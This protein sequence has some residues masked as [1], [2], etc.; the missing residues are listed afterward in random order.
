MTTQTQ[1]QVHIE[2]LRQLGGNKFLAM[3]GAKNLVY[4]EKENNYLLMKLTR[5]LSG[6]QYLKITLTVWD[7]YTMVFSKVNSKTGE[8]KTVKEIE[9]V[10]CDELQS[11]FSKVT[12]L[13]TRL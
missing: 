12:G 7:T 1:P 13:Y 2:I 8:I 3:T 6:A 10:Y 5:N 4:S 11:I 9:N